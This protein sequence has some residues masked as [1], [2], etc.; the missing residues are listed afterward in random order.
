MAKMHQYWDY[1]YKIL[2]KLPRIHVLYQ[3]V[4][5]KINITLINYLLQ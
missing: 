5:F 2:L 3:I 4:K 1:K